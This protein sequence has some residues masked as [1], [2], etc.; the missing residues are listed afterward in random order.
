MRVT[1]APDVSLTA[2]PAFPN[3]SGTHGTSSAIATSQPTG[4]AG[5]P[6][7]K[8]A[9]TETDDLLDTLSAT[10]TTNA[11]LGLQR[12]YE[13][14]ETLGMLKRNS[15]DASRNRA[16]DKDNSNDSN[17][18]KSSGAESGVLSAASLEALGKHASPLAGLKL[19][20]T[21]RSM[22]GPAA[23]LGRSASAGNGGSPFRMG[24]TSSLAAIG[25]ELM[26]RDS[27]FEMSNKSRALA[28]LPGKQQTIHLMQMYLDELGVVIPF[29]R[30]DFVMKELDLLYDS[31]DHKAKPATTNSSNSWAGTPLLGKAKEEPKQSAANVVNPVVG[32]GPGAGLPHPRLTFLAYVF[33]ALGSIAE[34]LPSSYL[35]SYNIVRSSE[36]VAHTLHDW[37]EAA[38]GCIDAA[39]LAANPSLEGVQAALVAV[40]ALAHRFRHKDLLR[41]LDSATRAA[42]RLGLD[43]LGSADPSAGAGPRPDLTVEPSKRT[44]QHWWI[45]PQVEMSAANLEIGRAV[46]SGILIADWNHCGLNGSYNIHPHSYTTRPPIAPAQPEFCKVGVPSVSSSLTRC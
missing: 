18:A 30:P 12:L 26:R 4:R 15:V 19:E 33:F 22:S 3:T 1:M 44:L 14:V 16:E 38:I 10:D 11:A 34:L 23:T 35:I 9:H 21:G 45:D 17:R 32:T 43:R 20:A 46:W 6:G 5:N 36:Q 2:A 24:G 8:H 28:L 39:E 7:G 42:R 37:Q 41:L 25:A 13:T 31:L 40:I 27:M 29:V